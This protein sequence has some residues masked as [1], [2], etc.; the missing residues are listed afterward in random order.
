MDIKKIKFTHEGAD[1]IAREWYGVNWPVVYILNNKTEIY[2]GETTSVRTRLKQHLDDEKKSNLR[3]VSVI[4]NDTFNKS[5][6]L[7]IESKLIEYMS[8]DQK[9]QI[10]NGNSGMRDHNFYDKPLYEAHFKTIWKK[11][12]ALDYV[13][14]D[15][16]VLLNSDLFKYTPYKKLTEDQYE[17]V[18]NIALDLLISIQTGSTT[19]TV[20]NGEAGTGK[21]VLAMYLLKLFVDN[22]VLNLVAEEDESL[23]EKFKEAEIAIENFEVAIVVPMTALRETLKQVVRKVKGLRSDMI[24]GPNDVIKKKYDLLIVDESHRLYRR[25]SMTGYGSYDKVNLALGFDREAT[26]LD[27]LL[28]SSKHLI[29]FYDSG[30]TVRPS[31][32]RPEDFRDLIKEGNL[33]T[34]NLRSQLRVQGGNDYLHY[35]KS[36]IYSNPPAEKIVF[37][38][39]D[40]RLFD[41]VTDMKNE[42]IK[43]ND[44]VG[45]SRLVAGYA[46]E[47]KT[48]NNK[49]QEIKDKGLYDIEIGNERL[50]WNTSKNGWVI[51]DNA[52]NEVGSIHTVQGYDLNYAGV[53]LGEDIKYDPIQQ[54]V[55]IDKK[56]YF[57]SKGKQGV[58]TDS[59]LQEYILNIYSVLLTRGI[60]GTY[61]YICDSQ[62]FDYFKK[63]ITRG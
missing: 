4:T 29:L 3:E 53:I 34:Y 18:Y 32:I 47:W 42:I 7:D 59:E 46:W 6:A 14:H 55:I 49:L 51:S 8:A 23:Y 10:M 26:Q 61:I 28:K 45:L 40:L 52:I 21:T 44:E 54:K 11:L 17:V 41:S 1:I 37:E 31:D 58:L 19:T 57:D 60:R 50:V 24:I 9:Y 5:A 39:Y 13:K 30:Q 43:R 48:K 20:V 2:I 56:S 16:S 33:G 63:Y 36:L 38:N 35:I 12:K 15:L 62:L 25:K 27:W 22:E